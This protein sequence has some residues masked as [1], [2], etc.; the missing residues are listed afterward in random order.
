ML[1][2]YIFKYF[3]LKITQNRIINRK[4]RNRKK[5]D[6]RISKI[7]K[8]A[9]IPLHFTLI[10]VK[11]VVGSANK[12]FLFPA[13]FIAQCSCATVMCRHHYYHLPT[14]ISLKMT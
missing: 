7:Y 3:Y 13:N 14:S 8:P 9:I 1:E 6:L 2:I 12:L 4:K 11:F 5:N 10:S